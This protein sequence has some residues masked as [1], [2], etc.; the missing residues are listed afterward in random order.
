MSLCQ[1]KKGWGVLYIND[2]LIICLVVPY[3]VV[4]ISSLSLVRA[5]LIILDEQS[6]NSPLYALLHYMDQHFT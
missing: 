3:D 1:M 4:H 6:Y 2:F 5:L